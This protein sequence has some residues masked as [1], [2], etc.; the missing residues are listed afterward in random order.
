MADKL[1][2]RWCWDV[3]APRG[4]WL[5]LYA[6]DDYK[7]FY[8]DWDALCNA[9]KK[10]N[11][12]LSPLDMHIRDAVTERGKEFQAV[13]LESIKPR[14][15]NEFF[16]INLFDIAEQTF[17]KPLVTI[18]KPPSIFVTHGDFFD[19]P[20]LFIY[21]YGSHNIIS[22]GLISNLLYDTITPQPALIEQALKSAIY[23]DG[24]YYYADIHDVRRML[25]KLSPALLW[26]FRTQIFM[27]PVQGEQMQLEL[28]ANPFVTAK[29]PVGELTIYAGNGFAENRFFFR[30]D[31][32]RDFFGDDLEPVAYEFGEFLSTDD[33]E[34]YCR[35][36]M[37]GKI[38]R[39]WA[40]QLWNGHNEN[41][42]VIQKAFK[43]IHW[44][45]DFLPNFIKEN[46]E[47][48][49]DLNPYFPSTDDELPTE[50]TTPNE[51]TLKHALKVLANFADVDPNDLAVAIIELRQNLFE[52]KQDKIR[53]ELYD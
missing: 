25:E 40:A 4:G 10:A 45:D 31:D 17:P 29:S 38:V 15:S 16:P 3:D 2:L 30:P 52:R 49:C 13:P 11:Y 33:G 21:R 14:V 51:D 18:D 23:F 34:I 26:R 43:F 12:K 1:K 5:T 9:A 39:Y 24:E 8:V 37:A 47:Y 42:T 28:N 6:T 36:D 19:E 32:L 27:T 41:N 7:N 20:S 35:F 22:L 46:V 53:S 50:S 48:T 44:F